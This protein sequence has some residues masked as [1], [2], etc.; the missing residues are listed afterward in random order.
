MP[1]DYITTRVRREFREY[2]VGVYLDRIRDYFEAEGFE[3][4]TEGVA[5]VTGD[6]RRLVESYY[7][8]IDWTSWHDCQRLLRVYEVV[9]DELAARAE[10]THDRDEERALLGFRQQLLDLLAETA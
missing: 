8:T 4:A 10:M 9:L 1:R 2:F 5:N 7:A 3:E 6:R